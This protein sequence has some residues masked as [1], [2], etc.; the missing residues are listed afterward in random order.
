M[1]GGLCQRHGGVVSH[2]YGSRGDELQGARTADQDHPH[3]NESD[4]VRLDIVET[5]SDA[6]GAPEGALGNLPFTERGATTTLTV[7]DQKTAVIGGLVAD[8]ISHETVKIPILGDIPL[9]GFLFRHTSDTKEKKD[10]VLVLTP[11]IIRDQEDMRRIV[12][13]RMEERQELLDHEALFADRP[14]REVPFEPTRG[15]L[16]AMRRMTKTLDAERER[17]EALLPQPP[18]TH[19][20][21][22][23]IRAAPVVPAGGAAA[24]RRQS[25]RRRPCGWSDRSTEQFVSLRNYAAQR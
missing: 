6:K 14:W 15:L 19:E 17:E 18:K 7:H 11:Y 1:R 10:L 24:P 2:R 13:R 9:L 20:P 3:L 22:E 5:I 8:T 12:E 16:G 25:P 4:D 21:T 23:P